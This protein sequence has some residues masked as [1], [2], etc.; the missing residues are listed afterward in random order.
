MNN[1]HTLQ[2]KEIFEYFN[3]NPKGLDKNTVDKNREKFGKNEFDNSKKVTYFSIFL[4]QFKSSFI[5][6]LIAAA[7][8]VFYLGDTV[9]A[10]II[11][12]VILL[13]SV[14]GTIQEGKARDTFNALKKVVK[15]KATVIRD[16]KTK[17]V[18]DTEVVPGDILILKDGDQVVADARL[19]DSNSLKIDEASLTGESTPITK[20]LSTFLEEKVPVAER[21]N[22]VFKG[23]YVTSGIGHAVVVGTGKNTEIGKIANKLDQLDS[24]VPLKQNIRNLSKL[25]IILICIVS[26]IIFF[27]GINGGNT[28]VEMFKTIVAVSVSAVPESLPVVVTLVL[29]TGVWRMS[30]KNVLVKRLQAVEALGQAKV[31]ALD[32]TGTITKN[33]MMVS[34]IYVN[35]Q[36]FDVSGTGYEPKGDISLVGEKVNVMTNDD[37]KFIGE[38]ASF[39]SIAN[40]AYSEE[41]KEWKRILGDPTE[42]AMHVL[43]LKLGLPKEEL[44]TKYK[45]IFEIPFD[46][47]KK[48]HLTI[49]KYKD[50]NLLSAVG[51]P[52]VLLN[53]CTKILI[54]QKEVRLTDKKKSE[55]KKVLKDLSSNGNRVLALTTKSN[56]PDSIDYKKLSSLT[57][58]GFVGISDVIRESV[59]D[60]ILA[61]RK[62]GMKAVVIT[63]DHVETA[64][65][66]AREVGI[67]RDGDEVMSGLEVDELTKEELKDRIENVTV[68]ARVSPETKLKIIEAYKDRKEIVA[69]TGDGINDSLSLVAADLGVAMGKIG[70]EVAQEAADIILL[71]DNFGN[72]AL[73]AEE[74][75]N[76]YQTIRKAILYLLST[77]TGEVAVITIAVIIGLPLPLLA[78]QIIWVNM[79]TDTFLVAAMAMDPK[80]KGL[81]SQKMKK[82]SRWI[83]D[84]FMALRILLIGG[85]MTGGTLFMFLYYLDESY[86]KATAVAMTI[87][88]V[89][90]WYNIFNVRSGNKSIFTQNPFTN[91]FL[92]VGLAIAIILHLFAI[93]NPFMQKVL[94]TTS[95]SG[96]DWLFILVF[97]LTIIIV[98]EIRKFVYRKIKN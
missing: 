16:G 65:N 86:I 68:F 34:S 1:W 91:R 24:E 82:T 97:G 63:G 72:I 41:E 33:Q 51:S 50:G 46:Y 42:V 64:R 49:N 87:I 57:F 13:N 23:T 44:E 9:D 67:Y 78:T 61:V 30:R 19:I 93:Y 31:I 90:Q 55:I 83:V 45:K 25:I 43:S 60:A 95:L 35:N 74:G 3:S 52:E 76:I 38:I 7:L 62:A 81:L 79:V 32:K 2:E 22:M 15:G 17:V 6:I 40:I 4:S 75:R 80:E 14:I 77:N 21:T 5:Y 66:I 94:H 56:S 28:A 10:I 69:M 88:T 84:R 36:M 20:S 70:T 92:I 98:E 85:V 37:I 58:V 12:S 71:D 89:Y 59:D 39:T 54:D 48:Y 29:A 27:F 73:A 53:K 96:K 18:L 26:V 47:E 8:I 11:A